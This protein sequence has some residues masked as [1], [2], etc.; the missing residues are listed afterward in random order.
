M[1]CRGLSLV[2]DLG[3]VSASH[4]GTL[5][6]WTMGGDPVATLGGHAALVYR[7]S[8]RSRQMGN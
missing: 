4:D 8:I 6:V 5:Q 7:Y 2:P 3:F 1:L